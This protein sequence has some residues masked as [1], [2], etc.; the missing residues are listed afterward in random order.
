MFYLQLNVTKDQR[1]LHMQIDSYPIATAP[2]MRKVPV[3]APMYVGGLPLFYEA[4]EPLVSESFKGCLRQMELNNNMV[5]VAN[6]KS[7]MGVRPCFADNE[8]GV[9]F[10]GYGYAV[11]SKLK[12]I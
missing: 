11:Y 4:Q 12:V 1:T 9:H 2:I 6:S 5:D 10:D 8:P 7:I 3:I